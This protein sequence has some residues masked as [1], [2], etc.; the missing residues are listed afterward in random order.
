MLSRLKEQTGIDLWEGLLVLGLLPSRNCSTNG[1]LRCDDGKQVRG[2][3]RQVVVVRLEHVYLATLA[4]EKYKRKPATVTDTL[5]RTV[6]T[7]RADEDER[8]K[9]EP[10]AIREAIEKKMHTAADREIWRTLTRT[11]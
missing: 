9:A 6:D 7:S 8:S 1:G 10:G 5:Y 4:R 3:C 2:L 11:E